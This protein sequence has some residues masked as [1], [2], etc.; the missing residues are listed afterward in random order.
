NSHPVSI[1]RRFD[2]W[3]EII[4]AANRH[5]QINPKSR[6]PAYESRGTV[7]RGM[8]HVQDTTLGVIG[9]RRSIC[10][11]EVRKFWAY[12]KSEHLDFLRCYSHCSQDGG[13]L[14]VRNEEIV[15]GAPIPGRV[16]GN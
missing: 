1:C 12:R 4:G 7:G 10:A 11:H 16:Y 2:P 14:F 3:P 6:K 13:A 5:G 15:G 8:D 9:R